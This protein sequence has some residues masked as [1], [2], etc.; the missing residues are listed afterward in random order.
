M[1]HKYYMSHGREPSDL[2]FGLGPDQIRGQ[3][4]WM[5]RRFQI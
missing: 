2:L 1:C 3:D 5:Y 4:E